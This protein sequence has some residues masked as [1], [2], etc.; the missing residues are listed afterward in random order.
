MAYLG[1]SVAVCQARATRAHRPM[2]GELRYLGSTV[3]VIVNMELT[4]N[5]IHFY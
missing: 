2:S 4:L 5:V 1:S 3:R